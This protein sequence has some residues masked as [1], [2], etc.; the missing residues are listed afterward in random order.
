MSK[1]SVLKNVELIDKELDKILD[2]EE[3]YGKNY[4][5]YCKIHNALERLTFET[6]AINT[7]CDT[8]KFMKSSVYMIV[9][10]PSVYAYCDKTD[11]A[12]RDNGLYVDECSMYKEL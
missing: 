9:E 8:C 4:E 7:K 2:N 6:K 10:P 1:E 5:H 11:N 3:P 12:S